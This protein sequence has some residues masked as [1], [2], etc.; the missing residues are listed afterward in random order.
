RDAGLGGALPDVGDE[1]ARAEPFAHAFLVGAHLLRLALGDPAGRLPADRGDLPLELP[2]SRLARVLTD[3]HP[4][5]L[6]REGQLGPL[7]AVRLQLFRDEVLAGDPEL[8]FLRVARA[9]DD[10]HAVEQRRRDRL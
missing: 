10:V 7:Q 8:L 6:L 4:E 3:D 2:H 9:V 1:A 5:A